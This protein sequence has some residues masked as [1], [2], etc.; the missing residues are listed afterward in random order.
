MRA[1]Q[2][3]R[4]CPIGPARVGCAM[5]HLVRRKPSTPTAPHRRQPHP[6]AEVRPVQGIDQGA[7]GHEFVN[8]R[9]HIGF[10]VAL[11]VGLRVGLGEDRAGSSGDHLG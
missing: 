2:L 3:L 4:R 11:K 1:V 7:R 10:E 5:P 9:G 6:L 8:R